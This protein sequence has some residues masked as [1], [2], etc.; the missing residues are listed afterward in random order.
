MLATLLD[1]CSPTRSIAYSLVLQ[2][3]LDASQLILNFVAQSD[4]RLQERATTLE[5]RDA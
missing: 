1:V 4:E 5:E 3:S 2:A